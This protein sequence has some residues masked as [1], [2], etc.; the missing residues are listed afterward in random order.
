MVEFK[1]GNIYLFLAK[2]SPIIISVESD[3]KGF[4]REANSGQNT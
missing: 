3:L 2:A 1:A 4:W